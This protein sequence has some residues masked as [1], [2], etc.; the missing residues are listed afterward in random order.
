M[1]RQQACVWFQAPSAARGVQNEGGLDIEPF[2]RFLFCKLLPHMV[3][4]L[5]PL[6]TLRDA[7]CD[8]RGNIS[9]SWCSV[10]LALCPGHK[11]LQAQLLQD[12]ASVASVGM[13]LRTCECSQGAK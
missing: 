2:L 1:L 11:S 9:S 6:R 7:R 3:R 5:S 10:L 13:V 8:V 4:I 12:G